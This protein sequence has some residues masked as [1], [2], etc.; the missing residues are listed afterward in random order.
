MIIIN[1]STG[2]F[3]DGFGPF[4]DGVS[5]QFTGKKE[6][7]GSLDFPWTQ[8]SS[9]IE[10]HELA[11]FESDFIKGIIDEGVH[12][13]HS[14]PWDTDLWVHLFQN[15]IDVESVSL[16][17]PSSS[18]LCAFSFCLYSLDR[19]LCLSNFSSQRSKMRV[20]VTGSNGFIGK[21][22]VLRLRELVKLN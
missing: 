21:N 2:V 6:L 14:L 4:W 11:G 12:D 8:G 10:S 17:S 22:L 9:L 15:L 18:L 16:D 5:G 3:G 1:S 20:L 7:H 13:T 19:L